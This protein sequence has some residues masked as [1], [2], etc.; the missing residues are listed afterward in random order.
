MVY[1]YK[2]KMV[3]GSEIEEEKAYKLFSSKQAVFM[4][5]FL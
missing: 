2:G 3:T 5:Q 1:I 4:Y